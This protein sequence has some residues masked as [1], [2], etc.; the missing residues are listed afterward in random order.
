MSAVREVKLKVT[1][2]RVGQGQIGVEVTRNGGFTI[3]TARAFLPWGVKGDMRLFEA[4]GASLKD[5][6]DQE[7][8]SLGTGI[9]VSRAL[10]QLSSMIMNDTMDEIHARS[11]AK[12]YDPFRGMTHRELTELKC[13]LDRRF[14]MDQAKLE[15]NARKELEGRATKGAQAI[16]K[17]R[18]HLKE[19]QAKVRSTGK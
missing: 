11:D 17:A 2:I 13:D 16:T 8:L 7:D 6:E 14:R 12:P 5:S 18:Q 15:S 10:R 1:K 3:A 4:T 9:S 19:V